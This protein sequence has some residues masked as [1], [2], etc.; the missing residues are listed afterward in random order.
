MLAGLIQ[1]PCKR[2]R[3]ER[4]D[5]GVETVEET[6]VP[7]LVGHLRREKDLHLLSRDSS[8]DRTELVGD[9]LLADEEGGEPVHAL[10]AL[11]L[12]EALP[13]GAILLEVDVLRAPLL[14]L[15]ELV[16]LLVRQELGLG[17]LLRLLERGIGRLAEEL[18]LLDSRR[19]AQL[20]LPWHKRG[21]SPG[22]G[23]PR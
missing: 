22:L 10:K 14:P 4:A 11:F 16:Q 18:A 12:G 17:A 23:P 6:N 8:D 19:R 2:V 1:P 20:L 21:G 15:P 13:I 3:A 5:L 9:L 7:S